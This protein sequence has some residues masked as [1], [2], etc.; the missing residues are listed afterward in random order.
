MSCRI[1]AA[2]AHVGP[3]PLALPD[4]ERLIAD[5]SPGFRVPVGV[6][7]RVTGVTRIHHSDPGTQTSDY[8]AAA[9][10][11]TLA[12]AGLTIDDVDLLIFASASQD[13]IEPATSH[14]VAA[15][16]GARCPVM[17]VK[18]ACNSWLNG[19]QVAEAMIRLGTYQRALIVSGEM[20]S[21]AVRWRIKDF[22]QFVSSVPGYT[23]SDSGAAVL[24][25]AAEPG[26]R[27]EILHRWF[28]A[29]STHWDVGRLPT[30]GSF[31]PR[32][33]DS[34]HFVIDGAALRAAFDSIDPASIVS[35]L[36]AD[37]LS[38]DDFSA[39]AV[40]QVAMP[41]LDDFAGKLGID[42]SLVVESLPEHGNCASASLPLQ[43]QLLRQSN[44]LQPGSLVLL[45]GL[46][47]G[48]SVGTM[49]VRW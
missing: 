41:Y 44:R 43:L 7:G 5:A 38:I 49:A 2:T 33:P 30:G 18:N 35:A 39:F 26:S 13:M 11:A 24:V 36:A 32:D 27:G 20:P 48:I 25:E 34:V 10:R 15:K 6:V 1:A 31:S 14:I 12:E 17:D 19:V 29:D 46:A 42:R 23:M 45:V 3:N 22:K 40:H 8:A 28:T 47:G 9:G 4:V 21:V 37:G 16:L